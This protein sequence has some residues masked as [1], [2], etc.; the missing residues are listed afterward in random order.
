MSA[1]VAVL[2]MFLVI[3]FLGCFMD[4]ISIMLLTVPIFFRLAQ[5]YGMDPIWLGVIVMLGLEIG[6]TTPPFG[7]LLFIMQGVAPPGTSF[8]TI[9]W[10]RRHISAAPSSW[11]SSP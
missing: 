5:V 8:E 3:L 1:W 7:L 10:R 9:C 11:S 4:Q 6:L 2:V